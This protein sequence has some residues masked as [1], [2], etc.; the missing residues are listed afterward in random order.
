[1]KPM[2]AEQA[3]VMLAGLQPD[4][5]CRRAAA[6]YVSPEDAYVLSC[7]GQEIQV[8]VGEA[9]LE[10]DTPVGRGL[11]EEL[12][13]GLKVCLLHYLLYAR[14][15]PPSGQLIKPSRLPGGEIYVK[16]THR[17]PLGALSERYGDA[18]SALLRRG[19]LLGGMR[20]EYGDAS[21]TVRPFPHMPLTVIVWRGD[22]EFP[23]NADLLFDA[24]ARLHLPAE[25]LYNTAVLSTRAF[26][27][28]LD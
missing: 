1:M 18:P 14:D 17:L 7:F 19:A 9:E 27:C 13:L 25:M 8:H 6:R 3:W 22:D 21:V 28:P 10:C 24:T 5:V 11:L 15:E 23:A 26:L 4:E 12:G 16:G 20:A 2:T